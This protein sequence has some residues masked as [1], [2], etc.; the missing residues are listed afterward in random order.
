MGITVTP[1]GMGFYVTDWGCNCWK[2]GQVAGRLWKITYKGKSQAAP[3]PKWYIAAATGQK[4]KAST[5]ELVRALSHPAESVRMVAQ[6]RLV[7]RGTAGEK[8]LASLLKNTKA[9]AYARWSAIW[10]LDAIDGGKK[11]HKVI[12]A[13]LKDKDPTVQAQ[14]ARELGTR[15]SKDATGPLIAMLDSTNAMLRFR[16]ATALGRIGDPDAVMPLQQALVQTDLFARYAAFKAL[17]RLGLSDADAWP[18]IVGGFASVNPRI[19]EGTYFA[20]RETYDVGLVKALAAFLS[21]ETIPTEPRTNVLNLLSSLYLKESPWNGDW[22]N[23]MPVNGSPPAKSVPW[24]GSPVIAAAM[25]ES[26]QDPQPVIRQ[27]A[28]D[29]VR[30]FTT[31]TRRPCC[32]ACLNAKPDVSMRASILRALTAMNDPGSRMVVGS[33]LKPRKRP[34]PCSKPLS[35]ARNKW[36]ATNGTTI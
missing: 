19:R 1:Y 24:A 3:K 26:L 23:T 10:T 6:R 13:A 8:K 30:S 25:R 36:A 7:A 34:F 2:N 15:Q 33:I 12:L 35:K 28:F 21:R 18:Q 14:A 4:F 17:N 31:Q 20:T 22:W 29:W 27:I 16:A 11:E 5:S 32:G 9:P